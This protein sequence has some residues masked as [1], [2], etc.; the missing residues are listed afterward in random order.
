MFYIYLTGKS[1]YSPFYAKR[2]KHNNVIGP[3]QP[4]DLVRR[5]NN[6]NENGDRFVIK[7]DADG[8][9]LEVPDYEMASGIEPEPD[10]LK[11]IGTRVIANRRTAD[12]PYIIDARNEKINLFSNQEHEFY[13]G[14]IAREGNNEYCVFFDDGIVQWVVRN[15]IRHVEGTDEYNHGK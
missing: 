4:C 12:L 1:G 9:E 13:P 14:I 10:D 5:V 8:K 15:K 6:Q 7:F 3:W 11:K 2:T